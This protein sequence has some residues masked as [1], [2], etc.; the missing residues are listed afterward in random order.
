MSLVQKGLTPLDQ[1]AVDLV[2]DLGAERLIAPTVRVNCRPNAATVLAD[3]GGHAFLDGRREKEP[4]ARPELRFAPHSARVSSEDRA[5]RAWT[6]TVRVSCRPATPHGAKC[7]RVRGSLPD[8]APAEPMLPRCGDLNPAGLQIA[9][10]HVHPEDS[11]CPPKNCWPRRTV[12]VNGRYSRLCSG[13]WWTNV[14]M[15]QYWAITSLA[16][17][18]IPRNSIRRASRSGLWS[19]VSTGS[20]SAALIAT[21]SDGV[22]AFD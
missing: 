21:A 20:M 9:S 11:R 6:W 22:V 12:S 18:I 1:L 2:H 4:S 13:L 17:R 16:R 8:H 7:C 5:V 14:R 15:G 3:R 10:I 19:V